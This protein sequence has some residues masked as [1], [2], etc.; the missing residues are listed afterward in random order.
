MIS[1]MPIM[2]FVMNGVS[3]LIVWV[4]A[5][6]IEQSALQVG[7]M[8]A[9]IQY[10]MIIIMAF[11]MIAMMFIMVPRASVSAQRIHEVLTTEASINDPA[12]PEKFDESKRGLVEFRTSHS[13][14]AERKKTCCA[15]RLH[16]PAGP[17]H[18]LL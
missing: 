9:F 10:A 13:N 17:D 7:D 2:M 18:G 14:T 6:Q 11:L 16:G 4:G 15:H 12:H 5:H 1:M 3:L 8:M